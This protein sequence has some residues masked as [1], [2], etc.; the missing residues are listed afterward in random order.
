MLKAQVDAGKLPPVADRL[1]A[2]PKVVPVHAAIGQYGGTWRMS[3]AGATDIFSLVRMIGYEQ[4]TRWKPWSLKARGLDIFPEVEP[5]IAQSI[6]IADEGRSYTFHLRPGMRWS[7]G[8]PFGADDILFWYSDI[9]LNTELFPSKPIWSVRGGKPV[10]VEKRDDLTVVFHFEQPEGLLPQWMATPAYAVEPNIPTAYPKHYLSQFHKTY[11]PGVANAGGQDWVRRFHDRANKW[12]NPELPTLNPWVITRGVG[13]ASGARV[14][15]ER[16]PYY[17]KVDSEGRQL[18]YIDRATFD[19]V[20]DNQ[21]Q[22]LKALNG[23]YDIVDS[24]LGFVTTPEHKAL[25]ADAAE[26]IGYNFYKVVPDRASLMLIALNLVHKDPVRRALFQNMDFRRGLSVAINRDEI[27]DLVFLGQGLPYQMIER[28]DSLLFDKEMATQF[29]QYDP[30]AANAYL[31][32]AELTNRNADGT[33]LAADGKPVRITV[34]CS[35][36]RQPWIN[37]AELVKR[38]WKSVGIELFINTESTSLLNQRVS[39][40]DHDAA[41]WSAAAGTDTIFDPKY[42][43]PYSLDSYFAI[44]WARSYQKLP[45]AE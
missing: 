15:A 27:I 12:A 18:P 24:Y 10:A 42:Y 31:D 32:K 6:D 34:E 8:H 26:K 45:G 16:N 5:N 29:T 44:P 38:Y 33:R 36:L 20:S 22:L 39:N 13:Q 43:F 37:S 7:D 40:N 14:I 2:A 4:L 17:W 25:F 41:I 3:M 11:T 19:I 35:T 9:Y 30:A 28:P 21:V 23:D 1:P